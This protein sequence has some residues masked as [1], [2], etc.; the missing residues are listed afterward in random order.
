[1]RRVLRGRPPRRLIN[2]YGPTETTT[3]ATWHLVAEVAAEAR[4][5]PIG[6]PITHTRVHLLDPLGKPVP[7]GVPGEIY[8]G[9]AGVALGYWEE[10]ESTAARFLPDPFASD[11]SARL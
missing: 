7:P 5:I 2:V 1:M 6:R 11:P 3:F 9:G 10:P 4:S 8:I